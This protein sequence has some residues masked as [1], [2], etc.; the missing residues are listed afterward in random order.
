MREFGDIEVS[1]L[2]GVGVRYDFVTTAG[3]RIGLLVQQSGAR[4]LLLFG[5]D[6]PDSARVLPLSDHD[7]VR[8]G[9]MLG[10]AADAAA[11]R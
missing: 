10:L 1:E 11:S 4:E 6:D 7:L 2:P 5:R 9:E 8:L 3:D